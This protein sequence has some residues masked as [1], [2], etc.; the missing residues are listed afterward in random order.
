MLELKNVSFLVDAEGKDKEII[1]N[2]SLT[3]PEKKLVVVTG[4]NGG[5]KSTLAKLIAGIEKPTEG[6]IFFD[7]RDITDL[8]VTG[9]GWALPML[10]S[11]RCG[12]R[13]YGCWI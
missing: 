4:P 3:V 8:G 13:E 5:G 2:I 11:S 7:G 6:R 12:S 9:P 1:R 10:F